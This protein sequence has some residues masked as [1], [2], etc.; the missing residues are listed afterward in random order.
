MKVTYCASPVLAIRE[1]TMGNRILT[2]NLLRNDKL[3]VEFNYSALD[4]YKKFDAMAYEEIKQ[5][6]HGFSYSHALCKET[7]RLYMSSYYYPKEFI[8]HFNTD[9]ILMSCISNW[10]DYPFIVELLNSGFKL[11]LGGTNFRLWRTTE[12]ITNLLL[13]MGVKEKY[14]KNFIIVKGLVDLKTDLHEIIK[15]WKHCEITENDLSTVWD[16][17]DDY[18]QNIKSIICSILNLDMKKKGHDSFYNITFLTNNEC[19]WGKCA[20]CGFGLQPKMN[21][22]E[23]VNAEVIAKNII[24]TVKKFNGDK[25]YFSNDYFQF[26][27]KHKKILEIIKENGINRINCFTGIKM[28]QDEKYLENCNKYNFK[29]L[30]VGL[31]SGTDFSLSR[32]NKGYGEE[33]VE[34]AISKMKRILNKD[35]EVI[36]HSIPDSPQISKKEVKRNYENILAWRNE[37]RDAGI[38]TN[39]VA[40]SLSIIDEV[41]AHNLVDNEFIKPCAIDDAQ[42]GRVKILNELRNTFGEIIDIRSFDH[43]VPFN[44]YDRDGNIMK[45]DFEIVSDDILY[46]LYGN[47]SLFFPKVDH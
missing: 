30:K 40:S 14:I 35:T 47:D 20:F 16:G 34:D 25:I 33:D 36:L 32:L 19:W 17:T 27:K 29:Y 11:V 23:N 22:D 38:T 8:N 37:L 44:R 45:T 28:M 3:D 9:I 46:E 4:C 2:S 15:N 43:L 21:F 6:K 18:L 24:N 41:N 7:I 1:F 31:E 13:N 42:S 5:M 10:F 26:T 39:V 12:F